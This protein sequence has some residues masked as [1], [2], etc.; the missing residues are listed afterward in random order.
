MFHVEHAPRSR[1]R[2][3][4]VVKLR[5]AYRA[6][7]TRTGMTVRVEGDVLHYMR[8]ATHVSRAEDVRYGITDGPSVIGDRWFARSVRALVDD[9]GLPWLVGF[10]GRLSCCASF[11][12][13]PDGHPVAWRERV[14]EGWEQYA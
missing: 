12:N 11:G 14:G 8:K 9:D 3:V 13:C 5:Q 10:G 7:V 4:T 6:P 1:C 2:K